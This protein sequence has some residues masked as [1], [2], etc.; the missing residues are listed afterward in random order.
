MIISHTLPMKTLVVLIKANEMDP[1][2]F[3]DIPESYCE[4]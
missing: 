2:S 3:A 1:S 4:I